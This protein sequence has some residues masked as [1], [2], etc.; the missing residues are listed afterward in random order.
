MGEEVC[1]KTRI[2]KN[3]VTSL[4]L[5]LRFTFGKGMGSNYICYPQVMKIVTVFTVR[6]RG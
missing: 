3:S 4:K 1:K 6:P 5:L 2:Q